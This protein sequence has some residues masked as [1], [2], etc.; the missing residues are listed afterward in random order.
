[1][2]RSDA[3]NIRSQLADRVGIA[4][5][6]LDRGRVASG[7]EACELSGIAA[8]GDDTGDQKTS[9]EHTDDP[10]PPVAPPSTRKPPLVFHSFLVVGRSRVPSHGGFVPA[11]ERRYPPEVEVLESSARCSAA[12]A[13]SDF[14]SAAPAMLRAMPRKINQWSG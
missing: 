10:I 12:D 2:T 11:S 8:G 3:D 14:P 4:C 6:D 5:I 1:M 9:N 7:T 13:A